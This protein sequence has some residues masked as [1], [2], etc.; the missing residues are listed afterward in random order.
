MRQRHEDIIKEK[1]KKH[2]GLGLT[3]VSNKKWDD[4][5]VMTNTNPEKYVNKVLELIQV[6]GAEHVIICSAFIRVNDTPTQ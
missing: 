2:Q 4:Y 1:M 6:S 5:E 3:K